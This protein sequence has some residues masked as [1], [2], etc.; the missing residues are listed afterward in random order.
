MSKKFI[1]FTII[2]LLSIVF[3]AAV[4]A[5]VEGPVKFADW[6]AWSWPLTCLIVLAAV[7]VVALLLI[8][9]VLWR[10]VISVLIGLAF[11]LVFNF[12]ALYPG[13]FSALIL[14]HLLAARNVHRESDQ[15]TVINMGRILRHGLPWVI[16]PLLIMISFAYYLDPSVQAGARAGQLPPTVRQTIAK[17]VDAFLG[18][19]LAE[20]PPAQRQQTKN[21]IMTETERQLTNLAKPY[22]QYL[23]P[24]LAFGLFLI[25][26]G[27]S[28]VFVWPA[29]WLGMGLFQMLRRFNFVKIAAKQVEVQTVEF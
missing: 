9:E 23:P 28:F 14:L 3:W 1:I 17:T 5:W 4:K 13:T 8:R 20:L 16:T 18:S 7:T 11:L 2:F 10:V 15:R 12:N 24:V 25:L 21:Q 29:V 26:Q 6:Q 27:L 19:E 22:F